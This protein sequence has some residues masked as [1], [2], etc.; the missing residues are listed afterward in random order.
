[1]WE[2]SGGRLAAFVAIVGTGGTFIGVARAL[3][4]RDDAIRCLAVEPAGAQTLAGLAVTNSAHKL[5][6][7]GYAMVP[8]QW[9]TTLC[10][11]TIPIGDDEAIAAARELARREGILAGFST[12]A[13]VAAAL[14]LAA[15]PLGFTIATV[16]CDTGTRYLSTDLFTS[17]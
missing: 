5:Q 8:P 14:G 3:K 4:A 1:L 10:D 7:A 17:E 11:G 6:G 13:N 2:Q 9:D 15:E 12:G 16:A